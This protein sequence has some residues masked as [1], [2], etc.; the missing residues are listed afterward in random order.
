MAVKSETTYVSIVLKPGGHPSYYKVLPHLVDWLCR[1][2]IFACF[3][4]SDLPQLEK[5]LKLPFKKGVLPLEEK[6]F[7][8]KSDLAI[9]LGG[10]GTLIGLARRT[11]PTVPIMG[12]NMGTLGFLTEFSLSELYDGLSAILNGHFTTQKI[13][14]RTASV[15]RGNKT[16]LQQIF[17]NDAVIAQKDISRLVSLNVTVNKEHVFDVRGDGIIISGPLGSTAYSLAAGGPIV[18][19]EVNAVIITPI[20]AH[21]LTH[22]PLVISDRHPITIK[23]INRETHLRLTLD[24][25]T[26]SAIDFGDQLVIKHSRRTFITMVKNPNKTYYETL[27][28]KFFHGR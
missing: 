20:C 6:L 7:F 17:I 13:Y 15:K 22:R 8:S 14:L 28:E 2:K 3:K 11:R 16:L 12:V 19:P 23:P 21:S 25:Q 18:H 24:G 27:R 1:R 5:Y 10:D 26:S 9:S 4:S